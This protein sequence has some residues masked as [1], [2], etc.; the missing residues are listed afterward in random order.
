MRIRSAD[1][2]SWHKFNTDFSSSTTKCYL[3]IELPVIPVE[4]LN[5]YKRILGREVDIIDINELS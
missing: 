2:G 5:G 3:G 4:D 1:G